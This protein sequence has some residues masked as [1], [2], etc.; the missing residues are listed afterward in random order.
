MPQKRIVTKEEAATV[1]LDTAIKLYFED[2]DLISAHTLASASMGIIDGLYKNDRNTILSKQFDGADDPREVTLKF[3]MR[4][5]WDFLAKPEH[6]NE[7]FQILNASQNFFKHADKDPGATH[8]FNDWEEC[9]IKIFITIKDFH[10]VFEKLSSAMK[11][12]Q[13]IY[14][15]L[16]PNLLLEGSHTRQQVEEVRTQIGEGAEWT[17]S[18]SQIAYTG[19]RILKTQCPELF[20]EPDINSLV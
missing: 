19:I 9:G 15:L 11:A 14:L 18:R 16:Y 8:E 4:D 2:R 1:Q 7:L 5:E 17:P 13:S 10:L 3:G 6:K 12:F 20:V